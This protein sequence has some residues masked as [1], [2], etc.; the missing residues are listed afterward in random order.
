MKRV[1]RPAVLAVLLSFAAGCTP[2]VVAGPSPEG[3]PPAMT[4][5]ARALD[6]GSPP[7]ATLSDPVLQAI[8]REAMERSQLQRLAQPLLDSVGPRLN[9]SPEH[10]AGNDW[11]VARYRQWGIEARNEQ[12][13]TWRRWHRG[14]SHIDLLQP[15]VRSLEGMLLAWSPGTPQPVTGGVVVL[16]PAG[17]DFA[18]WLPRVRGNFVAVSMPQPTCRPDDNWEAF[19]TPESLARMR[20]QREAAQREWSARLQSAGFTR[21]PDLHRALEAAGA[22]GIVTSLWS[23][24]WGVT[25]VF[26]AFTERVPTV[27]LSCEDYGLVARLA[28]AGQAPR[29]R[30][31]AEGRFE[32]QPVPVHNTIAEVRGR[33][34]PDEYVMLSAHFDSWDGGS[35][36]TDNGTGTVLMMEAMRILRQVYPNPRRTILVGHWGG[37]EQGLNG[38]RAF[39]ADNPRV[40]QGLHVLFNQDNGT[41]RVVNIAMQGFAE[42]DRHF[43][44]WLSR[45]PREVTQHIRLTAPG[46]PATGGTDHAAFVCAGAPAFNL[47]ALEWEYRRYTWHTNRDTY[48]KI[49]W[50]DLRSNAA[51]VAMLVYLAAEEPER[52]PRTQAAPVDPQTGQRMAWPACQPPARSWEESPRVR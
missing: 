49:V 7:A 22:A 10:R 4:D 32:P 2:P 1:V 14:V 35:G 5:T 6:H 19:A 37:E 33:E 20:Q 44:R 38:S 27:E 39:V 21:A 45:V 29:L 36:A 26:N 51:L 25:R 47:S 15:R 11:L 17:T 24:G 43:G 40:V 34:L 23:E 8:W 3:R 48:D 12:Y 42:A 50:D 16:P 31:Y 13:G 46:V 41:G 28:E 18:A 52:M 30:V 9:A